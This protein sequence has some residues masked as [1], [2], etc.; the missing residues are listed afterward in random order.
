MPA[1]RKPAEHSTSGGDELSINTMGVDPIDVLVRST[2]KVRAMKYAVGVAGIAATVAL[3]SAFRV[4]YSILVVG[5]MFTVGLMYIVLSFSRFA[6]RPTRAA[7]LLNVTLAWTFSALI[8]VIA[9]LITTA[10]SFDWP[11][12]LHDALS[13]RL[14]RSDRYWKIKVY[15]F[16]EYGPRARD[17]AV[18]RRFSAE[19]LDALAENEIRAQKLNGT[20]PM[21]V[22]PQ[23]GPSEEAAQV[24]AYA[25]LAPAV[26]VSGYVTRNEESPDYYFTVRVTVVSVN[27]L[28]PVLYKQ[29]V[30]QDSENLRPIA[31]A[32]AREIANVARPYTK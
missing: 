2:V 6:S 27:A 7:A 13:A 23:R 18:G 12:R 26:V 4:D 5:S 28:I 25:G 30:I 3:V 14:S 11:P 15:D 20:D 8:I 22:L 10:I 1:K 31:T 24:N 32:L 29:G 21:S 19:I 16:A 17:N 9:T